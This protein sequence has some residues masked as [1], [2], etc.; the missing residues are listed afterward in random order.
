MNNFHDD[1]L[2]AKLLKND[3]E[4]ALE[5]YQANLGANYDAGFG[6]LLDDT[7]AANIDRTMR[8]HAAQAATRST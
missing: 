1:N 3:E 6:S 2:V 5:H 7:A 8:E 4:R